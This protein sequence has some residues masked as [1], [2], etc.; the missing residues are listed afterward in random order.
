ME[1]TV[2][3]LQE[4]E[5]SRHGDFYSLALFRELDEGAE[6]IEIQ[7]TVGG[8]YGEEGVGGRSYCTVTAD[9]DTHYGGIERV[10]WS[11]SAVE[12]SY[13]DAARQALNLADRNLVLQLSMDDSDRTKVKDGIRRIF[14][15]E[16]VP[17]QPELVNFD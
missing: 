16:F 3:Q 9:H 8:I 17:P 2:E 15:G 10:V 14:A 4:E 1:L 13:T 12:I 5:T 6:G 7:R 11:D